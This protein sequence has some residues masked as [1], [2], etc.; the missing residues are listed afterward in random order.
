MTAGS[1]RT[2]L[3]DLAWASAATILAAGI[4]LLAQEG[5]PLLPDSYQSMLL[6]HGLSHSVPASAAMGDGGSSWA[7]PFYRLGYP[8]FTWPFSAFSHDPFMPGLV[9]SFIAGVATVPVVY[10]LA[11]AGL[12]SRTAAVGAALAAALSF[13]ATAWSRFVMSEG[14]AM[15][16]IA[17]TLLLAVATG[18]T[19]H[20]G[21][22]ILTGVSAA[23]MILVRMELVLLLPTVVLLMHQRSETGQGW[24]FEW[25]Y[26][27]IP[28][29]AAFVAL[30]VVCG[31]LAQNVVE[32]FTLNP[33]YFVRAAFS[34]TPTEDSNPVAGLGMGS[35]SF[36]LHEPILILL[37]ALGLVAGH[38]RRVRSLRALWPGLLLLAVIPPR[39][40]IR[41]LVP[42][43]PL[44]AYAAGYGFQIVR[45][46]STTR[47][48]E[49]TTL[50][51]L[52]LSTAMGLGIVLLLVAQVWQTESRWHPDGAYEREL[53]LGTNQE[54]EARGLDDVVI[55]TY[56]PE[57][58]YLVTGLSARR[59]SAPDLSLC[60]P[61]ELE[62]WRMIIVVD[63]AVRQ[64]FGED[65]EQDLRSVSV[66]LFEI[67]TDAPYLQGAS[68][69]ADLRPATAYLVR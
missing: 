25:R 21:L 44:L 33:G 31:W 49:L 22:G 35:L 62:N 5:I 8:L 64:H 3:L 19:R 30:S 45:Q 4:R 47:L 69:Y 18:R 15:F 59:L 32:G 57:A 39:N 46:W 43:V 2:L 37:A 50:R 14:T 27:V 38:R 68:A 61:P 17:L 66:P 58:Y 6:A 67:A 9:V 29:L 42:L 11:L 1:K 55:C 20:P 41:F 40:D 28:G 63:E 7:I 34:R 36:V 51:A 16:W 54:I 56:S 24:D 60:I 12:Q 13:S 10:F 48:R 52:A 23:V 53:A 26:F 65:L